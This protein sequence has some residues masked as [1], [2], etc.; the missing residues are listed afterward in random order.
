MQI[1]MQ[2]A[3]VLSALVAR[4][5]KELGD[6]FAANCALDLVGD[7]LLTENTT[8]KEQNAA[9]V[10]KNTADRATIIKLRAER[11]ARAKKIV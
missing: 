7:A 5:T 4:L 10:E 3:S 1:N 11:D 2:D 6:T 9:L 8:L